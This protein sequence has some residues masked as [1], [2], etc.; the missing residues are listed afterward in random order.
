MKEGAILLSQR[1]RVNFR[2]F[3][4]GPGPNLSCGMMLKT[5]AC[6]AGCR[7]QESNLDQNAYLRRH[8]REGYVK[9]TK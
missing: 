6:P 8:S 9:P 2:I 1:Q 7:L 4:S 3:E 5:H